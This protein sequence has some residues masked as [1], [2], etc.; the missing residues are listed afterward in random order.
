MYADHED[1]IISQTSI[2]NFAMKNIYGLKDGSIPHCVMHRTFIPLV[3][4]YTSSYVHATTR[5]HVHP[6]PIIRSHG[7]VALLVNDFFRISLISTEG[8]FICF[9]KTPQPRSPF[10][11][12]TLANN[13]MH[14]NVFTAA[15]VSNCKK[16]SYIYSYKAL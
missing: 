9:P 5:K 7:S 6:Y 11:F 1:L 2:L 16:K 12:Q 8:K 4:I 14:S 15:V 13:S 3:N 10:H